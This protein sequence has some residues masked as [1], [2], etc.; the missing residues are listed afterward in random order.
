M[1]SFFNA[2]FNCSLIWMLY[3]CCNNSKTKHLHE[4]CTRLIYNDKRSSY[5]DNLSHLRFLIFNENFVALIQSKSFVQ[6]KLMSVLL[7]VIWYSR[8]PICISILHVIVLNKLNYVPNKLQSF[9][10]SINYRCSFY[11]WDRNGKLSEIFVTQI[12]SIPSN[13]LIIT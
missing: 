2:Q 1:N 3:S 7:L 4:R 8:F 9:V 5:E 10:Q 13:R 11:D 6:Q 12:L